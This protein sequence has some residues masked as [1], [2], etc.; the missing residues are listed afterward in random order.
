MRKFKLLFFFLLFGVSNWVYAQNGTIRG[1]VFDGVTG[2]SLPGVTIYIEEVARGTITDLDGKFNLSV[3]PGTWDVRVSFISY[4][5]VFVNEV[6]VQEGEV[7]LLNDIGLN[8]ATFEIASAVVTAKAI[9]NTENALLAMKQKSPNVFDGISAVTLRRTG[10]SDAAASVKRITGVS[11][12]NGKYVY[13][14]G[15][16]DRYTKTMLNGTDIPGLDPDRNTLQMDIFP[17]SVIDNIIVHKSFRADL[18]ADFTGGIVDIELKD[19]P[20]ERKGRISMAAGYNPDFHFN[21]DYLT[22]KGGSTDFL[23]FD[24][25]TRAI[26][27]TT[28]I[29]QYT[30]TYINEEA[31]ALYRSILENFN[32]TMAAHNTTSLM[33]YDFGFS[34]GNQKA[35]NKHTVGYQV[36]LSYKNSTD[37]YEN[38][39]FGRYGLATADPQVTELELRDQRTGDYGVNN[40]FLSGL[41]GLAIKSKAAKYR[42]NFL[43]LQNGESKAGIFDYRSSDVGSEFEAF[44]HALYYTQ[45]SL[46]NLLIDGKHSQPDSRWEIVWKL[47]PTISSIK[48]PDIR[49]TRYAYGAT[50]DDLVIGTESGFPERSWRE[51]SEINIS[52][53]AHVTHKIKVNGEDAELKFGGAYTFKERDYEVQTFAINVRDIPLTGDPNELFLEENLWPYLGDVG[54]GT[55]YEANFIPA[56]SNQYNASL[57]YIAAYV[58]SEFSLTKNFT[59]VIG[60]RAEN[61][62]QQYSGRNQL[63]DK[64]LNNE[65]VINDIDLFPSLNFIYNFAQNQNLRLSYSKTIAR[66]SFKELSY[67]QIFDPISGVTFI[68]GLADDIGMD[69]EGNEVVYWNGNLGSTKIHNIDFRWEY[70][71]KSG[72]LISLS[73]FYKKFFDPIEMVQF[74]TTQKMQIQP[75]N[76]GD[77]EVYGA[78]VEARQTL[79]WLS[80]PL[81]VLH[82]NVNFTYV[83][84]RVQRSKSEYDSRVLSA[85]TGE[86][87]SRYRDMAG[88]SPFLLN[89]GLTFK[90]EEDIW[91]NLEAGLYYNVQGKTLQVVGIKDRPDIYQ[92]PFHSLNFNFSKQFQNGFGVGLK[93]KNLLNSKNETIYQSFKAQKQYYELRESGTSYSF[94]LSYSF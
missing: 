89:A 60:I 33:D 11:V 53:V 86:T 73:G 37:F 79:D 80:E 54:R 64:I 46:T 50:R 75:R 22:Y 34:F 27:A 32:P 87:I 85:R 70:F 78:E 55:T 65:E 61:Y 23:G 35:I 44:Q 76:V 5:T 38:A 69:T 74:A 83:Q 17:T 56:N 47:S 71:Y 63:G 45:R 6:M 21:G 29:P 51:L 12:T 57:N 4:E 92:K 94:H 15:L 36:A 10:D 28:N 2:E 72:Q 7:T 30:E 43:H 82:L 25:G 9:R 93:I 40:V 62:I 42:V 77:G 67:A 84:S 26:P 18:P 66:P 31:G 52:S 24:D 39:V 68:G 48:D 3:T 8:E 20:E 90:G 58:S 14:R 59:S 13:V 19:F 88:Q 91:K 49:F 16:G 41:A 1:F 81:K